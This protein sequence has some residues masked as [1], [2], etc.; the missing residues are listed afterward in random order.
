MRAKP[1][2]LGEPNPGPLPSEPRTELDEVQERGSPRSRE[3]P[4]PLMVLN[5]ITGIK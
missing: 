3:G 4:L 5:N 2:E 1:G